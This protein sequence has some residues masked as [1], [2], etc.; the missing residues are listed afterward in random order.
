MEAVRLPDIVGQFRFKS[1]SVRIDMVG[2]L[3]HDARP[4]FVFSLVRIETFESSS[5]LV[6]PYPREDG[7]AAY[8]ASC[9]EG[10]LPLQRRLLLKNE[11]LL[12]P[13]QFSSAH[14]VRYDPE[15]EDRN[16]FFASSSILMPPYVIFKEKYR[17][18]R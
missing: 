13:A 10:N 5:F 4:S 16:G 15:A 18:P 3:V 6:G 8:A 2:L 14:K 11:F 9:G 7:G 1:P 12:S 17:K